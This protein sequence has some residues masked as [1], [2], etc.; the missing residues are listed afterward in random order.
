MY[1]YTYSISLRVRH[2]EIDLSYL[3]P[4]LDLEPNRVWKAGDC[5]KTPKNTPLEGINSQSYWCARIAHD[6]EKSET[7]PLEDKIAEWNAKLRLH[8]TELDTLLNNGGKIEYFIWIYCENNLGF[9]LS[10]NLL[11]E[12]AG[13]GISLGIVCDP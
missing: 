4:L 1:P 6:R 11:K 3:G 10:H 9:E 5:R 13:L 7:C 8:Q 12:I 2:P